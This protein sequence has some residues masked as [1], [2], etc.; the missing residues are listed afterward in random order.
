MTF[1]ANLRSQL[2]TD[3]RRLASQ[4]QAVL[5]DTDEVRKARAQVQA[6]QDAL[7]EL[8]VANATVPGV[9]A[10]PESADNRRRYLERQVQLHHALEQPHRLQLARLDGLADLVRDVQDAAALCVL[11]PSLTATVAVAGQAVHAHQQA[12]EQALAGLD[13][14]RRQRDD[15]QRELRQLSGE[16][17]VDAPTAR[18][19]ERSQPT[20]ASKIAAAKVTVLN[21]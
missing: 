4:L 1:V 16:P 2:D 20:L 15:A 8:E 19:A 9:L 17:V 12:R 3:T 21:I 6:A 18:P 7:W 5:V 11:L 13:L 14:L 10:G